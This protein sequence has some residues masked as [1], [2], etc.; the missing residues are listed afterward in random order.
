MILN[1]LKESMLFQACEYQKQKVSMKKFADI[2]GQ[3]MIY[4]EGDILKFYLGAH[5]LGAVE[6]KYSGNSE[7]PQDVEELVIKHHQEMEGVFFRIFTYV[8]LISI[9][10]SRHGNTTTT[11]MQ[12]TISK[13][14][15]KEVSNFA[16]CTHGGSRS[17]S[18]GEFLGEDRDL[19]TFGAYCDWMFVACFK[20]MGSYGGKKWQNISKKITEVLNGEISPFTMVDVSWALVH[21]TGSIFNKNTIYHKEMNGHGL[22]QLLDMQRGGAIPSLIMNLEKYSSK[23]SINAKLITP[24]LM[25]SVVEASKILGMNLAEFVDF[26]T[27]AEAG[28]L[29]HVFKNVGSIEPAMAKEGF[30]NSGQVLDTG[31]D[32]IEILERV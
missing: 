32:K 1:E 2:N 17:G 23:L 11:G 6:T 5:I 7:L 18:R 12:D 26:K 8:M 4:P 3:Q 30:T 25:E 10:E 21:N 15:N 16:A 29:S 19:H 20:G 28:A 14:Y 27:I 9:G 22:T 13:K 24:D 31:I